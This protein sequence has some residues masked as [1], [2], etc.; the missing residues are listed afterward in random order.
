MVVWG[1]V[2]SLNVHALEES[3]QTFTLSGTLYQ[4]GTSKPLQDANT[5]I[6]VQILNPDKTCLLYEEQQTI[7]VGVSGFFNVQVG[8]VRGATKRTTNDP[9]H[10]MSTIFQN[11]GM[12]FANNLNGAS[13][14][15]G[16]YVPN[17]G[18]TRYIRLTV[19]PSSTNVAD[20]LVP[21]IAMNS[22][23]SAIVAQSVQGLERNKILQVKESNTTTLNQATLEWL[24]N[25]VNY[26]NLQ[27]LLAG[28]LIAAP[29]N[30]VTLPSYGTAPTNP[31]AGAIWYDSTTNSIKFHNGTSVQSIGGGGGGIASIT[32]G[33]SMTANGVAGGTLSGPGTID[34]KD[35]G[36]AANT[37]TKVTVNT[38]GLVT[39]GS[40]LVEADVPTLSTAGKVSGSAINTGTIAG[41]TVINT[42]GNIT[43]TGTVTANNFSVNNI[44]SSN[45]Y[46]GSTPSA[47]LTLDS[48]SNATKG[49]VIVAPAG[50][51]VGIG[52]STPGS[53]LEIK[54]STS[55]STASAL[56]VTNS[57]GSSKMY[58][59]ND[60]WIGFGQTAPSGWGG[61]KFF[62]DGQTSI[63]G[64][65]NLW[66]GTIY[67]LSTISSG[68]S[69]TLPLPILT[70][71]GAE[72]ARFD[73]SGRLLVGY[74]ADQ[75]GGQ[76]FQVNSGAFINGNLGIGTSTPG[77]AL[78]IASTRPGDNSG[79]IFLGSIGN[80]GAITFARSSDGNGVA[81]I[82]YATSADSGNFIIASN[83]SS[84][85]L[86][87]QTGGSEHLRIDSSGKVGLGITN[88]TKKFDVIGDASFAST[89]TGITSVAPKQFA[90]SGTVTSGT[91]LSSG[92]L[93]STKADYL[94]TNF[95][96][97]DI[98]PFNSEFN[99]GGATTVTNGLGHYLRP[100]TSNTFSGTI[101]Q[102]V[103]VT[104]D[105]YIQNSPNNGTVGTIVGFN[106]SGGYVAPGTTTG[107]TDWKQI[108]IASP[109][110]GTNKY[111]LFIANITGAPGSNYSIYSAGGQN[112]L[113]GKTNIGT[114]NS[115]ALLQ[116]GASTVA[117]NSAPLKFDTGVLMTTP[118][119][120]AVEY[121]GNYL[122]LTSGGVRRS[123][124][125]SAGGG[126]YD[127][128]TTISNTTGNITMTPNT[129][130]SVIINSNVASTSP[131]T[132]S[133]IVNGGLGVAGAIHSGTSVN[134]PIVNGGT[135]ASGNLT[136]DS[137]SNA[138]KGNI[139]LA[140]NGGNVGIGN[141]NPTWKL[142]VIGSGKFV[143][144]D[145][146][147]PSIQIANTD[148]TATRY[149]GMQIVNHMGTANTGYPI[150]N[151]ANSR[152][153]SGAQT[154][155]QTSDKLGAI[156][157]QGYDGTGLANSSRIDFTATENWSA[158]NL[159]SKIEFK[160]VPNGTTS[161]QTALT[162]D[163]SGNVGIG[164]S[165]PTH[166]F[167]VFDSSSN[168]LF[169]VRL[170]LVTYQYGVYTQAG[171]TGSTALIGS[172]GGNFRVIGQNNVRIGR[173]GG[174]D[175]AIVNVNDSYV[176]QVSIT[177]AATSN[178]PVIGTAGTDT[179]I[180]L[181]ISPKG[182]GNTVFTSGNVG[183]GGTQP[184]VP[185]QVG[186]ATFVGAGDDPGV[187]S[188]HMVD[189]ATSAN[190]SDTN[191][192]YSLLLTGVGPVAADKGG[193]IA[194]QSTWNSGSPNSVATLAGIK[195]LRENSTS[196]D[197]SGYLAFYTRSATLTT[198]EKMR[199]N[200]LGNVGI[201]TSSP[202]TILD[203]NGAET[204]RG[205]AAPAASPAGQGRIYFD[206]TANKFR[207]SENNGA[208][209]D[210]VGGG[211][212]AAS[213]SSLTAAGATNTI[214]NTTY[215]QAWNW[216]TA[217]TQ[218]PMAWNAAGLTTGNLF[219]LSGNA[220]TTGSLLNVTSSSASLN[221]TN[222]LLNVANT[223][224]ATTGT[225]AR[226]QSNSTAGSGL[227]V[228]ANG[229]IGIGTASPSYPLALN[230]SNGLGTMS[231]ANTNSSG[232]SMIDFYD[233]TGTKRG[234]LGYG[235]SGT[236]SP[237]TSMFYTH[238]IGDMMFA[239]GGT[240]EK[241][242]FTSSGNVGIG[243]TNPDVPLKIR[244]DVGSIVDA[245]TLEN[246][247]AA[248]AGIGVGLKFEGQNGSAQVN[249][250]M[251]RINAQWDASNTN[252]NLMFHTS[253]GGVTSNNMA[254]KYNGN[255]RVGKTAT[256]YIEQAKLNLVDDST[257][258]N[259]VL[260]M[261]TL[262]HQ[263]S[264]S[265]GSSGIGTAMNF[266]A[267]STSAST[268][269][270][271]ARIEA[272]L[273]DAT[274]TSKD[275]S[276]RLYTL[277]PN[278][279]AGSNTA[280]E[281]MRIDSSGNV[282]IGTNSPGYKLDVNGSLNATS[283][284]INGSA[285]T[286]SSNSAAVASTGG[287]VSSI[288]QTAVDAATASRSVLTLRNDGTGGTNEYNLIGL[289][290]AGSVTSY[291]NQS[292]LGSFLGGVYAPTVS[293]GSSASGNLTIDSTANATKGNITLA[294][295]GG[296]VGIGT[297]SPSYKLDVD[298]DVNIAS[299]N[300]LRF[301]GT[302]VCTSAGCTSSS[303]E[304]LKENIKP[305]EE[306]LEKI[307]Q[308]RGV[309]YDYKD[310]AKFG[311]GHQV[312]VIA[313]EVEKVYPEVVKTDSKTGF[314]AVAYDHLIAP[315]IEAVKKL[316][317][318]ITG[319]EDQLE[320]QSRSIASIEDSKA[321]KGEVEALKAENAALKARAEKSEKENAEIKA[322]LDRIEKALQAK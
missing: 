78:Q 183:I 210:L 290:A 257:G 222:G 207:V 128:V 104:S 2:F 46:G 22:A 148:S 115:S 204:V 279:G 109:A 239:P 75:G 97:S 79:H 45:I 40:N 197:I 95:S 184:V 56:N 138:T 258:G 218:N 198:S 206:S 203:I 47:N 37:Y 10:T 181:N 3:P 283:L 177:G 139:I 33:S 235:N 36:V 212:G 39:A 296:N 116:L 195:G 32:V 294:P 87:F 274:D 265:A 101:G 98:Y 168:Q 62:F 43:T 236:G 316:Y 59:R 135:A 110:G 121:D 306:P 185:L 112:Y 205:M 91:T 54:G 126:T 289:N 166:P 68:A 152:G 309:E 298:G 127:N 276:L 221:S 105:P 322:R 30:G 231:I 242:R 90:V 118:E 8:S 200:S 243:T 69:G 70:N 77:H 122:Y 320:I 268:Y 229:N 52:T 27:T 170:A 145:A 230:A 107:I 92:T 44:Y 65:L 233:N 161:P 223:S 41:N 146:N 113:A 119:N 60:G 264:N 228:L 234:G 73:G 96:V 271:M 275:A 304:R 318:R 86:Q 24:F 4:T 111:G 176:N 189:I 167:Q 12:M 15:G 58:V 240:A 23:P 270:E 5:K 194:F 74:N 317:H 191:T 125:T 132:G 263:D 175:S 241:V 151:L 169:D 9:N 66:N 76:K 31:T 108:S 280:T 209:V 208:Y 215:A 319:V 256:S 164:T 99:F 305:L 321:D 63:N 226:I 160:T 35:S 103:S 154:P 174:A 245:M 81:T 150:I 238:S 311:D 314:K 129:G 308:L 89:E 11:V 196:F 202:S 287:Q 187:S 114:T 149:P 300:A 297:T 281:R 299:A 120:G 144:T 213:L 93:M 88:P 85:N 100:Q 133:L 251:A 157:S 250:T 84:G 295:S 186:A 188:S 1:V 38:K 123:I 136:I 72:T 159:G 253:T 273:D 14:L 247:T 249:Q 277:G 19:T 17:A 259:A 64:S 53:S 137:T 190:L 140:P 260:T 80:A 180:D 106:A 291:I 214:D 48:T 272:V 25:N 244:S 7:S 266:L 55:D 288:R 153:N 211:A 261:L 94:D 156:I 307:L 51:N 143:G 171:G 13:C 201:G 147:Y 71:A 26:G 199:I 220:L 284:Y 252:A 16:I 282:G 165:N 134:A 83:G 225:I 57:S 269:P 246:E 117:A 292:G 67:N 255:L 141:T 315:L 158:T 162:I 312:G 6:L 302:S 224:A 262:L 192:G 285:F 286:P 182:T 193:A 155:L 303:D 301:G 313:Q 49:N 310:K 29:G 50:G 237:W 20:T 172:S 130:S 142:D 61:E 163:Q 34:I 219:S 18:D 232:F 254:L 28:G 131:T 42:T 179:N 21:D 173:P 216:S 227:T 102:M 82:G 293:G 278:Q 124:A 217:T 267:E 178:G 248:G